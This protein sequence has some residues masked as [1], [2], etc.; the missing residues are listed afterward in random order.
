MIETVV[1]CWVMVNEALL[2]FEPL[3]TI[4]PVLAEELCGMVRLMVL[5]PVPAVEEAVGTEDGGVGRGRDYGGRMT[6]VTG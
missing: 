5:F 2:T 6:T 3:T 4:L 1:V